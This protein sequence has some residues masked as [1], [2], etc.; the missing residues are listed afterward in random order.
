MST[1]ELV[2]PELRDGLVVLLLTVGSLTQRRANLL[3]VRGAVHSRISPISPP[4]KSV[5]RARLEQDHSAL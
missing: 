1:L 2:D 3:K 5:S 4:A